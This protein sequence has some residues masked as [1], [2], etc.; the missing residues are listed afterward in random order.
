VPRV[1]LR[2]GIDL[3]EIERLVSISPGIRSRFLKRVYTARELSQAK[4]SNSSLAGLFCVKEAVSKALGCGIGA[5]GWQE[6]ETLADEKGAPS[7]SLHGNAAQI[8]E[9]IGLSTWAVSITHT[10]QFAAATVTAIGY[11]PTNEDSLGQ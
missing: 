1:V 6:I 7:I 2:T 10:N 4:D 8:A 3:L 9:V 11:L 5:I